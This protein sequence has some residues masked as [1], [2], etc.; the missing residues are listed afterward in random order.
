MSGQLHEV[1]AVLPGLKGAANKI[2]QE[3][4]KVFSSRQQLFEG[5]IKTYR[6]TEEGGNPEQPQIHHMAT[7]VGEKLAHLAE[8]FS[9]FVDAAFQVDMTNRDAVATIKVDDLEIKDVPSTFLLQLDK[10]L[11]ELRGVYD[12]LPTLDPKF[13][14]TQAAD[15][16]KG[17]ADAEPEISYRTSKKLRHKVLTEAVV[18]DGVGLPAQI[19]KWTEDVRIGEW[20]S[21]RW[22]GMITVS[23]KYELLKRLDEIQK[24]VK[25][26][27]SQANRV[28]HKK[29]KVASKI[30]AFLHGN[31][32]LHRR[33][34]QF[35]SS[36]GRL[37][38][39]GNSLE[40]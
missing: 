5:G 8:I 11:T 13:K 3:T 2:L 20:T 15:K 34:E 7:T 28:D 30:F 9:P 31:L 16:G 23:Q 1:L 32:P 37:S 17:I 36:G 26:G 35:L 40:R 38:T 4:L 33:L 19:E 14:W 29:D 39:R 25:K 24:A 22:S 27:I 18:R 6:P 21:K 10:R 12:A